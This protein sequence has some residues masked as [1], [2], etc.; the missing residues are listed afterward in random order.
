MHWISV[1]QDGNK[2]RAFV[3]K[4]MNRG[5]PLSAGNCSTSSGTS[6]IQE[7]LSCVLLVV[8]SFV[9]YCKQAGHTIVTVAVCSMRRDL[10]T[11]NATDRIE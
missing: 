11:L 5:I 2:R 1:F 3:K 10:W 9:S 6:A 4:A 8:S 7:E